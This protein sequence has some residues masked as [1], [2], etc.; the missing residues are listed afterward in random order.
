MTLERPYP[1]DPYSLL[2][3]VPSFTLTSPYLTDGVRL[4]DVFSVDGEN[5]SPE[6]TWSGFPEETKSFVVNMYD[7][8]APTPSGFWHWNVVDVPA[9]TTSLPRDAGA[10]GGANL[11]PGAYHVRNDGGQDGYMGAAPPQGDHE[12]RYFF[13]VHALDVEKLDVNPD[14]SNAAVGF[15]LAFHTLARAVLV[16]TYQR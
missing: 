6:L 10:V 9:S 15:N 3:V 7:P 13:A 1:P 5:V 2:P 4:P 14:A 11:P 12:H 8:D 16:T